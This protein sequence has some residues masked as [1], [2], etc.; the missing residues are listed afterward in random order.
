MSQDDKI[1]VYVTHPS[2]MMADLYS[3]VL[4]VCPLELSLQLLER[5]PGL[6]GLIIGKDGRMYGSKG[7][8]V[9]LV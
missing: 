4:F 6:E 1:S 3:T 7:F 9:E 8:G 5:T 2:A